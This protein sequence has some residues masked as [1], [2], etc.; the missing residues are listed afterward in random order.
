MKSDFH[1]GTLAPE[2]PKLLSTD[3]AVVFSTV[4]LKV[5]ES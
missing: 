4:Q 2:E 5:F 1:P 3:Y